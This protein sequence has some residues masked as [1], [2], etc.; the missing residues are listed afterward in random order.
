MRRVPITDYRFTQRRCY[1]QRSPNVRLTLG[2]GIMSE[3]IFCNIIAG[4]VPASV[5]YRDENAWAFMDIQPV[6]PGHT[7]V[8]P[9]A[10]AAGLTDLD[11]DTGG[12]LF[13]V[14]QRVAAALYD[15]RVNCDGVNFVLADGEAAGQ[16]VFHVHLHVV[17]RFKGD[18]FAFQ[19]GSGYGNLPAREEL[20]EVAEQLRSAM[21]NLT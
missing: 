1:R 3:C 16:E 6:N 9:T 19:H 7:L 11:A 4:D 21:G 17:P 15:S 10:H 2:E 12:H 14:G 8:V 5:V 20:D 18:G 13:R